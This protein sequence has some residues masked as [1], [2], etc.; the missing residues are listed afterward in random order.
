MTKKEKKKAEFPSLPAKRHVDKL[1]NH[2]TLLI[3]WD[4]HLFHE[5]SVARRWG[6]DHA[7]AFSWGLVTKTAVFCIRPEYADSP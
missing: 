6:R 4:D 2:I 3:L 1:H 7:F 5:S